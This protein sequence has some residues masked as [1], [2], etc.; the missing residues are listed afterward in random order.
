MYNYK[1]IVDKLVDKEQ[2]NSRK[3]GFIQHK[4]EA[5]SKNI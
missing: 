4:Q 2:Q 3:K 5:Q 1:L